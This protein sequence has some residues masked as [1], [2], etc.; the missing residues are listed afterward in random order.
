MKVEN[1][2]FDSMK[3]FITSTLLPKGEMYEKLKGFIYRGE[4]TNKYTLLPAVLRESY[5]NITHEFQLIHNEYDN[6]R[7][8]YKIA[9][10]NGIKVPKI[11]YMSK[12]YM[13]EFA[14][15]HLLRME[16]YKWLPDDLAELAA[17]AQ[18]YGLPT[19]LLDWS[20]D[21]YVA[22]Y[23]ASKGAMYNAVDAIQ[24]KKFFDE[25]DTMVIWA[26]NAQI[27]QFFHPEVP[28][29]QLQLK[30]P[31]RFVVP[32]Y[33]SNP[34][35]NAQKGVLVY[36]E[37]EVS[38]FPKNPEK[39][40]WGEEV[41]RTPFDKLIENYICE[42]IGDIAVLYKMEIPVKEGMALYEY[43]HKIG[44]GAARLFPGYNGVVKEMEELAIIN[45]LKEY[46]QRKN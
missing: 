46:E 36:W 20:F 22:L 17:L 18:H 33:Y 3:D 2:K 13:S 42:P 15:E 19:R 44:Y 45:H 41:D 39:F 4:A 25:N 11:E 14:I 8:F 7:K 21:V 30:T 31:L 29:I 34:N 43:I 16:E 37:R 23:F 6:L 24:H 28:Q 9:N 38:N 5:G 12:N 40:P 26:L 1:I 35:L 32:S 27:I 10:N